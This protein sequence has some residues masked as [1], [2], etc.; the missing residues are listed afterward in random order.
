MSENESRGIFLQQGSAYVKVLVTGLERSYYLALL[1]KIDIYKSQLDSVTACT[2]GE[3]QDFPSLSDDLVFWRDEIGRR[4]ELGVGSPEESVMTKT[5]LEEMRTLSIYGHKEIERW[6]KD[7]QKKKFDFI[8]DQITFKLKKALG[9]QLEVS[10]DGSVLTKQEEREQSDQSLK[11][12]GMIKPKSPKKSSDFGGQRVYLDVSLIESPTQGIYL[13]DVT[14]DMVLVVKVKKAG[15]NLE[16]LKKIFVSRPEIEGDQILRPVLVVNVQKS[17]GVCDFDLYFC[18]NVY[19]RVSDSELVRVK[20]SDIQTYHKFYNE[21]E[22]LEFKQAVVKN[23]RKISNKYVFVIY[24]IMVVF[25]FFLAW[26]GFF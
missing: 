24:L 15:K 5:V 4:M 22:S 7:I 1:I 12:K 23:Q 21:G 13:S 11:G 8:R 2:V 14:K 3:N 16:Y 17:E 10:V 25:I 9:M 19:C 6:A 20:R 26:M 18:D